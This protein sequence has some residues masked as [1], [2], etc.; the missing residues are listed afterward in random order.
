MNLHEK[1]QNVQVAKV[2]W[3]SCSPTFCSKQN[4][5]WLLR[6]FLYVMFSQYMCK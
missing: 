1:S 5:F 6:A 3:K 4:K 2:F